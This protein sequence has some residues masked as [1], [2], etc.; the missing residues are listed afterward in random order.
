MRT[1][2]IQDFYQIIIFTLNFLFLP[3]N[4]VFSVPSVV[5]FFCF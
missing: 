2:W 3:L 5:K 4:S 1:Y